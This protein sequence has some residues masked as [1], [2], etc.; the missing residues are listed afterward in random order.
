MLHKKRFR[1]GTKNNATIEGRVTCA[2][3]RRR[4][5]SGHGKKKGSERRR[6][7]CIASEIESFADGRRKVQASN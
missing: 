1:A 3:L 2:V 5:E 6:N 7:D 4:C